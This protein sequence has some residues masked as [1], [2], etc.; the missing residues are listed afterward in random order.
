MP[1][2]APKM[3]Q[4]DL[5]RMIVEKAI[6]ND[7]VEDHGAI[8]P[9][10]P[11]VTRMLDS[12]LSNE[13]LN[14]VQ[15]D[16]SKIDF[17][18]ENM[19][20]VAEKSTQDGVPYLEI[21]AGGDW[22]TP[23]VCIVYFDGRRMRGYVP[24]AGNSYNHGRRSAFGN[25]DDDAAAC[26]RQFG[27][28]P[29]DYEG[30]YDVDPDM[31]LVEKDI[32]ERIVARGASSHAPTTTVSNATRK[33]ERQ[34]RIESAQDLSGPLT[35]DMVYAVI[36]PAAGGSYVMFE[37]RSSRRTLTIDEGER[38]VGVPARLER[39]TLGSGKDGRILWYSPSDCYPAATHAMLEAAGFLKAPD[40]DISAYQGARTVVV[41]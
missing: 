9:I 10:R 26:A 16:W 22:E 12:L 41:R 3:P 15:K 30:R 4:D 5:R 21:R 25:H 6:V 8:D 27:G 36:S 13:V 2:Y 1:R 7:Y 19:D 38:L 18:T 35:A 28:D 34:A 20:V 24:K 11:D 39:T 31:T 23:L 29:G 37:L 32:A 33:A 40:N 14:D 17:S